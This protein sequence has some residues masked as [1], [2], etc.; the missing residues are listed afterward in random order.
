MPFLYFFYFAIS[1]VFLVSIIASYGNFLFYLYHF[2]VVL[3]PVILSFLFPMSYVIVPFL[4][5]SS[6]LFYVLL[7]LITP[8]F[9]LNIA[10]P[11][12][13]P[14][15]LCLL[16]CWLFTYLSSVNPSLSL[17]PRP[18]YFCSFSPVTCLSTNS[19]PPFLFVPLESS[20]SLSLHFHF[21]APPS[22]QVSFVF[23]LRFHFPF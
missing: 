2:L 19:I 5:M 9:A 23:S 6:S 18:C 21:L 16:R 14:Y 11:L 17:H 13:I 4:F 12:T 20:F 15:L 10:L 3:F 22:P 7:V 8:P 1:H